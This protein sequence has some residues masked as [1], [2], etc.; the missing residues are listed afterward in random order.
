[1]LALRSELDGAG[2]GRGGRLPGGQLEAQRARG[3]IVLKGQ[4]LQPKDGHAFSDTVYQRLGAA[5]ACDN[6]PLCDVPPPQ[7]APP[8]LAAHRHAAGAVRGIGE[9]GAGAAQ[10]QGGARRLHLEAAI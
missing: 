8:H 3:L 4:L 1:M 9:D 7:P 6:M 5:A 2:L 10:L